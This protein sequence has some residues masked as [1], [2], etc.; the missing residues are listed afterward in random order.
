MD[1]NGDNPAQRAKEAEILARDRREH[2]HIAAFAAA[3][4][5]KAQWAA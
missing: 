1:S 4:V 5:P 2:H 3:A